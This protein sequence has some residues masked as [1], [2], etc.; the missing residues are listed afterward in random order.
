MNDIRILNT[1]EITLK[2]AVCDDNPQHAGILGT[3]FLAAAQALERKAGVELFTSA[4]SLLSKIKE[5]IRKNQDTYD[6]IIMDIRMPDMDGIEFG[7]KLYALRLDTILVLVTA[8]PEYA[9]E[10]YATHAFQFL[11]K[12][13]TVEKAGEV[14]TEIYRSRSQDRYIEIRSAGYAE[15][16]D[17]RNIEA[18]TAETKY[19]KVSTT[20]GDYLTLTSLDQYEERL[21]IY[22]FYRVHRST[23]VNLA[24]YLALD[25]NEIILRQNR[26]PVS[27]R[28]LSG[29]KKAI[30]TEL[31]KKLI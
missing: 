7:R 9:V 23:L 26:F 17:V 16:I 4:L 1:E 30:E 12:P 28:K 24:H 20:H 14:L 15:R 22:G 8:Y 2:I 5:D 3:N 19:T 25:K 31:K 10:G 13:V 11:I 27:R 6:I 29:L 21:A 18:I